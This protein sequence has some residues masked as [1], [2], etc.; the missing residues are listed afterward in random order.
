M[1]IEFFFRI[2]EFRKLREERHIQSGMPAIAVVIHVAD[3]PRRR[4]RHGQ[5]KR[6]RNRSVNRIATTFHDV[7][8]DARRNFIR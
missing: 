5:G 6:H 4:M 7:Y 8:T 1:L 3:V 2:F